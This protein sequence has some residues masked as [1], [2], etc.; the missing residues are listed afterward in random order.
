VLNGVACV[1]IACT[2]NAAAVNTAL[3]S[4]VAGAAEGRLQAASI[5]IIINNKET[6]RVF[7]DILFS[8]FDRTIL[9]LRRFFKRFVVG[10]TLL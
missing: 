4:S 1:D 6:K 7:L 2:V 5:K 8:S 3:G 9:H 10:Y